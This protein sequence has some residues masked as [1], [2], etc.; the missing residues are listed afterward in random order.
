MKKVV[1]LLCGMLVLHTVAWAGEKP[2]EIGT[3]GAWKTYVFSDQGGKVCFMSS[4]PTKQEGK[5]T[6]RGEVFFFVTHWATEKTKN[7]ISISAGYPYKAGSQTEVA[8]DGKKFSLFTE[9]ETAW[10]QDQAM[11]DDISA[12]VQKGS[13]IVVKGT[14]ARGTE[15]TDTY[16]LKGSADAY[17]SITKECGF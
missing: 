11:D 8:V 5:F 15:T 17:K 4:Q 14:S 10:A 12:A 9:G 3:F 2:R 13:K 1:F 7:V 6:K 16:S